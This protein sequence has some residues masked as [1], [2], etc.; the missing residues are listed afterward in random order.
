MK[1]L[2]CE[3]SAL[4]FSTWILVQERSAFR[5]L[6]A[7]KWEGFICCKQCSCIKKIAVKYVETL[8]LFF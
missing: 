2:N 3:N 6:S 5:A 4:N 7:V 8:K 1:S